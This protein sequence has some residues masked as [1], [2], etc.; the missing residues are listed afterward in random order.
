MYIPPQFEVTNPETIATVIHQ[1]GFASLVS[2]DGETMNASHVPLMLQGLATTLICCLL[3]KN[4]S[5]DSVTQLITTNT[6]C[7]FWHKPT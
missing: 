7:L 6:A 5:F 2:R 4:I 1:Y 3:R